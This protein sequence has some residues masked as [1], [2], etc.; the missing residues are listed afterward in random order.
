MEIWYNEILR[1]ENVKHSSLELEGSNPTL[2][3]F[4]T[5]NYSSFETIV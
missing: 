4:L 2:P 3:R 1:L 5:V